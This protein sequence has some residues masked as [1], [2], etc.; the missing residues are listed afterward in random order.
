MNNFSSSTCP[1]GRTCITVE[2]T[3][4]EGDETW[5]ADPRK[6]KGSVVNELVKLNF[7]N[8]EDVED[9]TLIKEKYGYP[10]LKV[11]D[12]EKLEELF[13]RLNSFRNLSTIGR[14]GRFDY[15]QM[16]DAVRDGINCSKKASEYL[17]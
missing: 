15:I 17:K 3:C 4:F 7:F 2:L 16:A 8:Q 9:Y 13:N 6:L 10:V 5:N 1:P 12:P 11:G 14:Q